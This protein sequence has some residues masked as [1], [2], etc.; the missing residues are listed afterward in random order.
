MQLNKIFK[1]GLASV[2]QKYQ[3]IDLKKKKQKTKNVHILGI[4]QTIK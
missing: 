2:K 3:E 1:F 4:K